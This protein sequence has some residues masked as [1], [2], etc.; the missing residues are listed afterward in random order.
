[1][2]S[3]QPTGSGLRL[4]EDALAQQPSSSG[5]AR[6][7]TTARAAARASPYARTPTKQVAR[8]SLASPAPAASPSMLSGL[9]STVT[10]P[11]RF[12]SRARQ[13]AAFGTADTEAEADDD[14][15]HGV[16]IDM[17]A[18]G[19][20]P[21]RIEALEPTSPLA[22][23]HTALVSKDER[24]ETRPASSNTLTV[25]TAAPFAVSPTRSRPSN[26]DLSPAGPSL[27]SAASPRASSP[28]PARTAPRSPLAE[29][30][31]LPFTPQEPPRKRATR[32]SSTQIDASAGRAQPD[33]S[34][35]SRNFELLARFFEQKQRE[36]GLHGGS[37]GLT[38][39][40]V[41]G[42][43][44]LI[45]DSMAAGRDLAHEFGYASSRLGRTAGV[46]QPSEAPSSSRASSVAPQTSA[47][48]ASQTFGNLFH[49]GSSIKPTGAYS[50][51]APRSSS[52]A[53]IASSASA[54]RHR[55]LYLGPGMGS[56][57]TRRRTLA[58]GSRSLGDSLAQSRMGLLPKS[59]SDT[60]LVDAARER[61]EQA[62]AAPEEAK[63]RRTE[64][65]ER[66]TASQQ[67]DARF[68]SLFESQ[69]TQSSELA[70]KTTSAAATPKRDAG[71]GVKRG[72][73]QDGQ[74]QGKKAEDGYVNGVRPAQ[75]STPVRVATKTATAML[76]ILKDSPPV[77]PPVQPELV[78]PYQP[79]ST[80]SK[81]PK[82]PKTQTPSK[83]ARA[84]MVT[85]A[86][87]RQSAAEAKTKN[88]EPKRE[89]ILDVI[90]R[91]A[92]K[93]KPRRG[94]V[95]T[96]TPDVAMQDQTPAAATPATTTPATSEADVAQARKAEKTE[97]ARRRLAA[98]SKKRE[99][100][101]KQD[102]PAAAS[103]SAPSAPTP[104]FTFGA[105]AS[106]Q[107]QQ[108]QPSTSTTSAPST[109]FS[110]GVAKP[111]ASL[112]PQLP[113][114]YT[115]SKPKKPSP[116]SV[117]FQA[118]DS[119]SSASEKS[120]ADSPVPASKP[121]FSFSQ[122]TAFSFASPS[123]STTPAEPKASAAPAPAAKPF[124]FGAPAKAVTKESPAP[125]APAPAK[126]AFSFSP[127]T[128]AL[129][130][131]PVAPA[132]EVA[133]PAAAAAPATTSKPAA[134]GNAKDE[135][136][137]AP[138]SALPTFSFDFSAP[139]STAA[140]AGPEANA[141]K[142][143]VLSLAATSLP[144]FDFIFDTTSTP[145]ST[146]KG[147]AEETKPAASAPISSFSFGKP[148]AGSSTG[149]SPTFSFNKPIASAPAPAASTGFSFSPLG[150]SSGLATP[151]ST[152]SR[153]STPASI[154]EPTAS[155]GKAAA[156]ANSG[157]NGLLGEGEGE[158]DETQM[159]EVRA[160]FWRF[161]QEGKAWKDLGIVI[162][163]LKK[164]KE[165]GKRRMLVR[166]E[167][168][169][170]VVVNFNLYS[171]IK[172]TQDKNVVSFLGF[173][174]STP[175]QFRCKIKTEDGARAFKDAIEREAA[176]A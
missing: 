167:A 93:E 36:G 88:E 153:A 55:P 19:T 48:P 6:R 157:S 131:S 176:A 134:P 112:A 91:T 170:K 20:A 8:T 142:K 96:E 46:R 47:Y 120:M 159:H 138:I 81:L 103:S 165:T 29:S 75:D 24:S 155:D 63:R 32:Y 45:E 111:A 33:A 80:L 171:S 136:V 5:R 11:F 14:N 143:E 122:P 164:H 73:P 71:L 156:A 118:P 152:L 1:M 148:A 99:A 82:K 105:P 78:N 13:S 161:D 41:E 60:S 169:G 56:Q 28:L 40:E 154:D 95:A 147:A 68:E 84:S 7:S 104:A 67:Q 144:T 100:D 130:P 85:R 102:Q 101:S 173:D 86:K 34:P 133:K 158:E 42:C 87:A 114:Q 58:P 109:G 117:T 141:I 3:R 76:D 135:A 35:V 140:A 39:V 21:A 132:Q 151:A 72:A 18:G 168:N 94:R 70:K 115:A 69:R 22:N 59:T 77:R 26:L 107:P 52:T 54:R 15:G 92:P 166:N 129:A 23:R 149:S 146:A 57:L 172:V 16:N 17:E 43:L 123:A 65:A 64:D 12:R 4:D 2:N 139:A 90:E 25:P 145:A 119:P 74:S 116:L 128:P 38:E 10:S 61:Q 160:K 83:S 125:P 9:I 62:N 51:L 108:Q 106:Q 37:S 53:S 89:S 30:S 127:I 174:G 137:A 163:K 49:P 97:E 113:Q 44:K 27:R 50:F 175:T 79:S 124:T 110:F 66:G 121:S 162:A 126:P 31:T 150:G 98:L